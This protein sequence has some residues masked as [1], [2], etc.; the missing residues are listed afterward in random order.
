MQ[1]LE[2][3]ADFP[4]GHHQMAVDLQKQGRL[5]LAEKAYLETLNIDDHYNVA[6]LNLAQLYYQQGRLQEVEALYRK[7]IEQEPTAASAHYSLG[8]LMAELGDFEQAEKS[9]ETAGKTG[10]NPRA[11]YNLAVLRHQQGKTRA[12]E[13]NYI[14]ALQIAPLNPDFLNGLI[15]LY[16]QQRQWMKANKLVISALAESPD[17]TYFLQLKRSIEQMQKQARHK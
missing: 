17:N 8:L 15:S 9:L 14:R 4:F 11:W 7:V 10:Q 12:A 16:A 2:I 6:R 5:S 1:S 13:E 3:N